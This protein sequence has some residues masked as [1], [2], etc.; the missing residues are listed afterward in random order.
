MSGILI[1]HALL[2][3]SEALTDEVPAAR[4]WDEEAP[5]DSDLPA[6][7]LMTIS[8]NDRKRLAPTA[9]RRL[10]ERVQ[11]TLLA[12]DAEERLAILP[13]LMRAGAERYV[14]AID[15]VDGCTGITVQLGGKGLEFTDEYDRRIGSW[16]FMVSWNEAA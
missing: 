15:G 7:S 13:L 1:V 14:A 3:A 12:N 16:D 2:A 6:I 11:A 9:S 4:I 5:Q 8:G 10:T